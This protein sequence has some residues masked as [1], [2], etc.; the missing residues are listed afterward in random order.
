VAGI[1][2]GG[3]VRAGATLVARGEFSIAIAALATTGGLG[4]DVASL[5]VA[6]V[7]L[8]AVAGPILTRVLDPPTR[9]VEPLPATAFAERV[10]T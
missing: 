3:R 10:G 5:T 9:K 1:G 6:Y 2:R 4:P 7:L 8:L